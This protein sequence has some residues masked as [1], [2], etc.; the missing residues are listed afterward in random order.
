MAVTNMS[1]IEK[2]DLIK[3]M[4]RDALKE[5]LRNPSGNF[6]LFLVAARLKE[7]E[8]M[9]RDVMARRAAQQSSQEGESVA[10]R[11]A[12]QAMPESPMSEI[13]A[14]PAPQ[15]RPDPQG[16]MAQQIAGPT[17]PLPTVMARRGLQGKYPGESSGID[18]EVLAAAVRSRQTGGAPRLY[19]QGRKVGFEKAGTKGAAPASQIPAQFGIPAALAASEKGNAYGGMETLPPFQPE[20]GALPMS[21]KGFAA[22]ARSVGS[23]MPEEDSGLAYLSKLLESMGSPSK[24]KP[25]VFAQKGFTSIGRVLPKYANPFPDRVP[26]INLPPQFTVPRPPISSPGPASLPY[27]SELDSVPEGYEQKIARLRDAERLRAALAV[28]KA[29]REQASLIAN[30]FQGAP[31]VS[32]PASQ[33]RARQRYDANKRAAYEALRQ[34]LLM[35]QNPNAFAGA[36]PPPPERVLGTVTADDDGADA[37]EE[38]TSDDVLLRNYYKKQQEKL[39]RQYLGDQPANSGIAKLKKLGNLLFNPQEYPPLISRGADAVAASN[40]RNPSTSGN[41][42][43]GGVEFSLPK[44]SPPASQAVFGPSGVAPPAVDRMSTAAAKADASEASDGSAS[45]SGITAG[46]GGNNLSTPTAPPAPVI[47]APVIPAPVIPAVSSDLIIGGLSRDDLAAPEIA[48]VKPLSYY[49]EQTQGALP[50]LSKQRKE[51]ISDYEAQLKEIEKREPVPK[52]TID[53]RQRMQNRLDALENSPLPFMTAAAAAIKGNQPILVAMTNAMIGYTAGDE[54]V[55]NQGL[56]I[57]GDIVDL[58]A[59]IATM[60]AKQSELELTA[61]NAL[62]KARQADLEGQDKRAREILTI[63]NSQQN[64]ARTAAVETAKLESAALNRVTNLVTGTLKT[65]AEIERFESQKALYMESGMSELEAAKNAFSD[66]SRTSTQSAFPALNFERATKNAKDKFF[67]E[68]ITSLIDQY[69][70]GKSKEDRVPRKGASNAQLRAVIEAAGGRSALPGD[71]FVQDAI[72]EKIYGG[73][74]ARSGG[75]KTPAPP[76]GFTVNPK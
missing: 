44:G 60:K 48:N 57:M 41:E 13:G 29:E 34:R 76:K 63:A 40:L 72:L 43:G 28:E 1:I 30:T 51:I 6:P 42:S 39:A 49:V 11:L 69:N 7:V 62:I 4:P 61:R 2:D 26:P 3:K 71:R 33:G 8:E 9:E 16:I 55:K 24:D 56:K 45:T 32:P 52:S 5:E 22:R 20:S 10:A 36:P 73:A 31:P 15:P 23:K 27:A 65:T 35:E 14:N 50:D 59:N 37:L 58:D 46:G 38:N 12:Q 64:A 21:V 53:M 68:D 74:A 47:P 75:G 18:Q 54:K 70:K 67:D 66:F 25:T 19:N 17:Q